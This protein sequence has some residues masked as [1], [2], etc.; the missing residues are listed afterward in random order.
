MTGEVKVI[1]P[2]GAHQLV[3][4][5][6]DGRLFRATVES[7]MP[8]QPGSQLTLAPRPDRIRWFDPETES[9]IAA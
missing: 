9:A 7:D 2:L 3:T 8:I 6:M 4:M 5:T 1:E